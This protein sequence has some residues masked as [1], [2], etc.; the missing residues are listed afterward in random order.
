MLIEVTDLKDDE[1][2]VITNKAEYSRIYGH[3]YKNGCDF[4]L[5]VRPDTLYTIHGMYLFLGRKPIMIYDS[6][7]RKS[8][9]LIRPSRNASIE[10]LNNYID[11]L[12]Q[13]NKDLTNESTN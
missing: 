4:P 12:E 3:E 11:Y 5:F 9:K 13:K 10:M 2:A 8:F 1:Y 7:K 6:A